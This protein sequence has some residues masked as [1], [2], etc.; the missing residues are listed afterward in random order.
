MNTRAFTLVETIVVVA[1]T[2]LIAVTLGMLLTYFYKTNAYTLEQST[3]VGTARH[4][5]EDALNYMREASYGS[6]GSYPI[7]NADATSV[8][9]FANIN[10]GPAIER[11]TYSLQNGTLYRIVA[12]P[13]GNPP[14][15]AGASLA[16]TT[17]AS[18][19]VNTAAT[20]VFSYFDNTGTEL[21]T[22]ADVSRV[23]SIK[24][25]LIID[26]NINRAPV[27]FTLSGAATLRNLKEQL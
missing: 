15:Y 19:I 17:V 8:T 2:A 9:F 24:T 21:S 1:M 6:D 12:T 4:G 13:D 16:T 22:P 20:P 27:S 7:A 5:V 3:A 11:V 26:V 23:T 10:N 14:T 18:S 25:T